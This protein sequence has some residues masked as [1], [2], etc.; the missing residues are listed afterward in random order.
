MNG[1]QFTS[2]LIS[3]LA[4]PVVV[5]VLVVIF[6]THIA[7]LLGRIKSYKG[8]GQEVT[9]GD[10]L[11][12]AENSVE[13]AARS[14]SGDESGDKRTETEPS[15][16]AREAEDNPSFVVIRAWEQFVVALNELAEGRLPIRNIRPDSFLSDPS[17]ILRSLRKSEIVNDEFVT[18]ATELRLLRN[19]VAHGQHNP[20]PGEAL[21]YAES[22]RS[23]GIVAGIM[24]NKGYPPV[25]E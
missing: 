20:T 12:V 7:S 6:R 9:F 13:E 5:I 1:L 17:L 19:K 23:L 22:A 11:A 14:V 3:T 10:G 4:W 2:S 21:A 24:S 16:L 18:A 25:Q 8:M 15:P